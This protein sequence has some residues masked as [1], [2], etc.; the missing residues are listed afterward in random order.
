MCTSLLSIVDSFAICLFTIKQE[1]TNKNQQKKNEKQDEEYNEE[2]GP[3]R[4]TLRKKEMKETLNDTKYGNNPSY[5][6][7]HVMLAG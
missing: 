4:E 3:S 5:K 1:E 6:P 2:Y 7:D